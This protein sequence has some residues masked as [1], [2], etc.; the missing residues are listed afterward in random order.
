MYN[1]EAAAKLICK[2]ELIVAKSC[3]NSNF[4]G[5]MSYRY[6]LHYRKNSER[7]VT[8][9]GL[10][11]VPFES[12]SSMYYEF[13]SNRLYIGRAIESILD[14]IQEKYTDIYDMDIDNEDYA[15][16]YGFLT[17]ERLVCLFEKTIA[18]NCY[19][20]NFN[21]GMYYRYPVKYLLNGERW[22]AKNGFA[23][24]PE[25]ALNTMYY[26]FG[27]NRIYIGEAILDMI[28]YLQDNYSDPFFFDEEID[29]D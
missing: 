2:L 19:N 27:T 29:D 6:P 12:I 1:S 5:G 4:N 17:H 16:E 11:N 20:S 18:S 26:Q 25:E 13:G 7:W 21:G 23:N 15:K 28:S 10:A 3:Y 8:K 22:I 9:G 24:V 14:Y